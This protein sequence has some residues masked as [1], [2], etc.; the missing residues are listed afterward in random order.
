MRERI[1]ILRSRAVSVATGQELLTAK[2]AEEG[3]E[4]R[5]EELPRRIDSERLFQP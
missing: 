2:V 4:G 5:E 3:R 1:F